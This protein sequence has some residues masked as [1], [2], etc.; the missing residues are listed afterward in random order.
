MFK[1]GGYAE[2]CA[3]T[4]DCIAATADVFDEQDLHL[5]QHSAAAELHDEMVFSGMCA[6]VKQTT[7][8]RAKNERSFMVHL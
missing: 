1:S 7:A 4:K 2:A 6:M 5:L 8:F 3:D